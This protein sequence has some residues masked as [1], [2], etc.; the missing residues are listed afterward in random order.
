MIQTDEV[1]KKRL[2]IL[3]RRSVTLMVWSG[4]LIT[5]KITEPKN[6]KPDTSG[7]ISET[8]FITKFTEI[9]I[10]RPDTGDLVT[11]AKLKTKATEREGKV[12]SITGLV[13]TAALNTKQKLQKLK[14]KYLV[15][16]I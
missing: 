8:A 11:N 5:T 15:L 13:T 4:K 1:L 16:L 12:P 10:K 2:K 9:G 3:I 6:N 14:I 7:L